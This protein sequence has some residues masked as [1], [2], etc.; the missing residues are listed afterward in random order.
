MKTIREEYLKH[1][2]RMFELMART[3][4]RSSAR[5]A[6]RLPDRDEAAEDAMM[7]W[8]RDPTRSTTR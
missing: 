3:R 4:P 8:L 7:P 6:N 2:A 1:I 5:R